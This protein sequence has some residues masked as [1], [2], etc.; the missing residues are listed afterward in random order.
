M[1]SGA[2]API[3]G[4]CAYTAYIGLSKCNGAKGK[5]VFWN[6]H[7]GFKTFIAL[8]VMNPKL[9]NCEVHIMV[10]NTN[11]QEVI[12][13]SGNDAP[14]SPTL[15]INYGLAGND[16]YEIPA[17]GFYISVGGSGDDQYIG[18]TTPYG[19]MVIET[20]NSSSDSGVS[21]GS[22]AGPG[23]SLFTIDGRHLG[24]I[25][26]TAQQ[27]F[28][29]IDF[30]APGNRIE[31]TTTPDGTFTFDQLV[32]VLPT[33]PS[34]IGNLTW[35]NV[36]TQSAYL[37]NA[38]LNSTS[39]INEVI[40]F[41]VGRAAS[42]EATSGVDVLIGT[43]GPETLDGLGGNDRI[44][45]LDGND[46]LLGGNGNDKLLGGSGN[47]KLLGGNGNDQ[48]SGGTGNDILAGG[49]QNDVL[50]GQ[51]GR[52]I[53]VLQKGPGQDRIAD[54]R[55]RI[56]RLGLTRGLS[57]NSLTILSQGSNTL[58][59]AGSDVLAVLSGVNSTAIGRNDFVNITL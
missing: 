11:L 5:T 24:F 8:S 33:L 3:K 7:T 22:L 32:T 4:F 15:T 48:L 19:A 43:P 41:I 28:Y 6:L 35:E 49:N 50:K 47:D 39:K 51:G 44:L 18:G 42:L 1:A 27:E 36:I 59:K 25:D 40:S 52:D 54:Y 45:G 10:L 26:T 14:S 57:F 12:L 53:F 30:L 29:L 37:T 31:T 2:I 46:V 13:T 21:A 55:D 58:I 23:V 9:N 34:F 38:G 20:G 17:N 56:D 16:V